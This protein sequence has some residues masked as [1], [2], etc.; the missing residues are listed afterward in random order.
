[1]FQDKRSMF[2]ASHQSIF[3]GC[4]GCYMF[5]LLNFQDYVLGSRPQS[6]GPVVRA[7]HVM[8]WLSTHHGFK[9]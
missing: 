5:G 3:H 4:Y 9:S 8:C 6:F 1:M 7:T 2:S